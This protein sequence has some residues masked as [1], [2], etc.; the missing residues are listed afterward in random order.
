MD[1]RVATAFFSRSANIGGSIGF[2]RKL[3]IDFG[4]IL[5][6]NCAMDEQEVRELFAQIGCIMEDASVTALVWTRD[7][8]LSMSGRARELRYAYDEIKILLDTIDAN[9]R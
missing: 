8:T 3:H 5:S 4:V 2:S 7:D 1:C 6:I 9:V